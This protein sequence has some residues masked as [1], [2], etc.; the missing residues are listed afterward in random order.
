MSFDEE[1]TVWFLTFTTDGDSQEVPAQ[2]PST[3]LSVAFTVTEEVSYII[4]TA[5]R[6]SLPG[7]LCDRAG[8][9]VVVSD[10][11][12]LTLP[13]ANPGR[14]RDFFVRLEISGSTVPTITFAAPEGE[15]VTFETENGSMPE[16]EAGKVNI[17]SFMET[18]EGVFAV[19]HRT[20]RAVA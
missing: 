9:R 6:P 13:A 10:D 4:I 11:T 2:T 14:A 8:N 12:T 15:T 1:G 7:H 20:V 5:T 18:A 19:A 17:V 16:L 3:A